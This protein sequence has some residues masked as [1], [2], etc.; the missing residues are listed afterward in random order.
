M[1]KW[2][3]LLL[4][5]AMLVTA[6]FALAEDAQTEQAPD[7][8][9]AAEQVPD[10]AAEQAVAFSSNVP[11]GE[12]PSTAAE[13]YKSYWARSSF[14][15]GDQPATEIKTL[16][17]GTE[18]TVQTFVSGES[19]LG[20]M[21]G[22]LFYLNNTVVAGVEDLALSEGSDTSGY[23]ANVTRY[24][25]EPKPFS[26]GAVGAM[27]EI[28]GEAAHFDAVQDLWQYAKKILLPG[29]DKEVEVNAY[30]TLVIIGNHAYM[31]EWFS[32]GTQAAEAQDLQDMKGFDEL[33]QDEKTSVNML[34]EFL[35]QQKKEQLQQYIDF[36]LKKHR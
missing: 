29:S 24:L 12:D 18:Y 20:R 5:T 16:A 22:M 11:F 14:V 27:A 35:E 34:A 7:A 10:A 4:A 31:A 36:L 15:F 13:T 28:I 32:Q 2:L 19:E 30:V 21:T 1:R 23:A 6:A 9:A 17:D 8:E 3:R 33:T 25:G 26:V